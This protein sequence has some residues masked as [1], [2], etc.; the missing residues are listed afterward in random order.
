MDKVKI[1]FLRNHKQTD[2]MVMQNVSLIGG[3]TIRGLFPSNDGVIVQ[4][5]T[6]EEIPKLFK[7]EV[8]SKLEEVN[9]RP[10]QPQ[11]FEPE[12]T[13][14]VRKLP[15][16]I[17]GLEPTEILEE[18]NKSNDIRVG[19]LFVLISKEQTNATRRTLKIVLNSIED[20]E[21]ATTNGITL[22]H[23]KA[24]PDDIFKDKFEF[25]L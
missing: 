12:R 6:K 5:Q 25:V 13:I 21:K 4:L 22:F 20:V 11:S 24:H 15:S 23:M 17:T 9:L 10:V 2:L 3:V 18:I 19:K 16:S 1:K 7:T 8:M 14:F